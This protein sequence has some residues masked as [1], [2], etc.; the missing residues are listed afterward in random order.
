[1][2]GGP[3]VPKRHLPLPRSGLSVRGCR[4]V[5]SFMLQ[6]LPETSAA[7][8]PR[9]PAQGTNTQTPWFENEEMTP[10]RGTQAYR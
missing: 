8:R 3:V 10:Q 1:M 6:K 4:G 7:P 9:C 5:R 2:E